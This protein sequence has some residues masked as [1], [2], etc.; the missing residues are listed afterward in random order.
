MLPAGLAAVSDSAVSSSTL[1]CLLF[2]WMQVRMPLDTFGIS[3]ISV[4]RFGTWH[5]S[6]WHGF[7]CMDSCHE[8]T[9]LLGLTRWVHTPQENHRSI[10][11]YSLRLLLYMGSTAPKAQLC[12]MQWHGS[13]QV[14]LQA[15]SATLTLVHAVL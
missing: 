8:W 1:S 6:C 2:L 14:M 15:Q 10:G 3:P 4:E 13:K 12:V 7:V 9:V 5:D 11:H